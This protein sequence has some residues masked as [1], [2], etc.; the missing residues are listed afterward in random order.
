MKDISLKLKTERLTLRS[1]N[2][3]DVAHFLRFSN[4]VGFTCFSVPGHH[5]RDREGVLS[6]LRLR[7]TKFE[8]NGIGVFLINLKD[9]E[10][11]IGIC[12]VNP[13]EVEGK[14]EMELGFRLCLE[15]WGQGFATEASR[16]ILNYA[17]REI[18]LE[19]VVTFAVPQNTASLKVIEKLGFRYSKTFVHANLLHRLYD[20]ENRDFNL[21]NTENLKTVN[22]T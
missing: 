2:E 8:T 21:E 20:L 5:P 17:F 22:Y 11:S 12:A 18:N 4:D 9:N 14:S 15:H 3:N 13:Y 19:K 10:E 6:Q 16:A 7:I 1:L